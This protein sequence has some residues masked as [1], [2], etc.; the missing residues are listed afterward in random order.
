M[1][2]RIEGSGLLEAE[3][4]KEMMAQ[5][6]EQWRQRYEDAKHAG[7]VKL[8]WDEYHARLRAA[9][10]TRK[11]GLRSDV[12]HVANKPSPCVVCLERTAQ[13]AFLPRGIA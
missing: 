4:Q 5:E 8:C 6:A 9:Y 13:A 11:S 10:A 2:E 3:Q 1:A 7:L 12:E